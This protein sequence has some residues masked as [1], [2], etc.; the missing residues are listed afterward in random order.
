VNFLFLI[1]SH[2]GVIDTRLND[3][4]ASLMNVV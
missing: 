3:S 1:I 2:I 4:G